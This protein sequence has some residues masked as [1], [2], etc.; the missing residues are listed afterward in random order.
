MQL[1]HLTLTHFRA[2][3]QAEF[4]FRPGLNLLVGINGVGKSTVLDALCILLSKALPRFTASRS[5]PLSFGVEDIT[6][7][8]D[9]LYAATQ[10]D[11]ADIQLE[12]EA[13]KWREKHETIYVREGGSQERVD[14]RRDIHRLRITPKS[15]KS[16]KDIPKRLKTNAE[17]PFAVYFSTRRSLPTMTAPSKHSSA[18]GQAPAFADALTSRELRLR[19]FADWW[20]AQETLSIEGESLAKQRL[21]VL[22]N[23]ATRF[24][25]GK[26]V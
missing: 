2:F 17:Q 7:G 24:L 1:K 14:D 3:E 23:A 6:V 25:E 8:R 13:R 19:E 5:K 10:F 22:Q 16:V 15:D 9:W 21:S 26:R 20:L 18:G 11:V 12:Y 4:D